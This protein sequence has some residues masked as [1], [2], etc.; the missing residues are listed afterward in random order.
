MRRTMAD[1][2]HALHDAKTNIELI[3]HRADKALLK[4]EGKAARD[5]H[6]LTQLKKSGKAVP[7]PEKYKFYTNRIY[8]HRCGATTD[9]HQ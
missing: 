3:Q 4:I 7:V 9:V 8:S 5:A 2:V 6:A 1:L